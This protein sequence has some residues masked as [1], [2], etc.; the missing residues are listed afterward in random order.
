MK[1]QFTTQ[2]AGLLLLSVSLFSCQDHDVAE[3]VQIFKVGQEPASLSYKELQRDQEI[4]ALSSSLADGPGTDPTGAKHSMDKQPR[5][6]VVFLLGTFGGKAERSLVI[7]RDRY[8]FANIFF[9]TY[10]YYDNDV[11]RTRSLPP[12]RVCSIF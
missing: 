7:P 9:T 12:A 11:I 6:D 8:I 3:R 1:K 2:L 4:F 10:W 5:P